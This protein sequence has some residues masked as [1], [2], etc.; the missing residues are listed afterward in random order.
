[1]MFTAC[2]AKRK[3]AL[4]LNART[5]TVDSRQNMEGGTPS[6]AITFYGNPVRIAKLDRLFM[7]HIQTTIRV[8]NRENANVQS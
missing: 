1:M 6:A 2:F 7:N 3:L 4:N 5:T 8:E